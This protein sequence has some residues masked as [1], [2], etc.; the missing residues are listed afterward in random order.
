MHKLETAVKDIKNLKR[1][2][3]ATINEINKIKTNCRIIHLG[4]K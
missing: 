1:F 2:K 4:Q 3:E